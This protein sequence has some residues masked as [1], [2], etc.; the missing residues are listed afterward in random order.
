MGPA[1]ER[2]AR[3]ARGQN[4]RGR[5]RDADLRRSGNRRAAGPA[6]GLSDGTAQISGGLRTAGGRWS[7]GF[8]WRE[9]VGRPQGLVA[10]PIVGLSGS[11][12][13]PARGSQGYLS[14]S[15]GGMPSS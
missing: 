9:W 3:L 1:D 7:K 11:E 2:I 6:G 10:W 14:V 13:Q 15:Q 12:R 8:P 5:V 4:G